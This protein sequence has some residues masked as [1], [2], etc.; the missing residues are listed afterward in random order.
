MNAG[1]SA[2]R[3]LGWYSWSPWS[4]SNGCTIERSAPARPECVLHERQWP[5]SRV[6]SR[7]VRAPRGTQPSWIRGQHL[8][9]PRIAIVGL[10]YVGL[11]LAVEFGRQLDTIDRKRVV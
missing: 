3:L 2:S 9:E 10:G 1:G 4:R 8:N 7:C 5:A 11:P 6:F